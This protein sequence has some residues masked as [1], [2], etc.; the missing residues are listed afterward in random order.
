MLQKKKNMLFL[1]PSNWGIGDTHHQNLLFCSTSILCQLKRANDVNANTI[2]P[3]KWFFWGRRWSL[4]M[5][6][7][8]KAQGPVRREGNTGLTAN[9]EDTVSDSNR[10][11][12][13]NT[14]KGKHN[15]ICAYI[16]ALNTYNGCIEVS[17]IA[18]ILLIK[19]PRLRDVK[20]VKVTQ[21]LKKNQRLCPGSQSS[22]AAFLLIPISFKIMKHYT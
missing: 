16:I 1:D 6:L 19:K 14:L 13:L 4:Y 11:R 18:P 22:K 7:Q 20:L 2:M 5:D 17:T 9:F 21:L 15:Y 10:Q 12:H 8:K 3:K